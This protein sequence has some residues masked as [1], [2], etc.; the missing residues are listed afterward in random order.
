MELYNWFPMPTTIHKILIHSEATIQ[1]TLLPI[2]QLIEEAQE[3]RNKD[4][5]KFRENNTRKTS[6]V[7]TMTDLFNLLLISADPLIDSETAVWPKNLNQF[8]KKL[9]LF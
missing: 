4:A 5:K 9:L 7:H 2:G 1:N 6:R 3:S 8:L